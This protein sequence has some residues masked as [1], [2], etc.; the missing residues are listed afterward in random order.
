[1]GA[2]ERAVEHARQAGKLRAFVRASGDEEGLRGLLRLA[3]RH[4]AEAE[5]ALAE[6]ADEAAVE[7]T[8]EAEAKRRQRP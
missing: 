5:K 1:M 7:R 4:T 2:V 6:L 8:V 3:A